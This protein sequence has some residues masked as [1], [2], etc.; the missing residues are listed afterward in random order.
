MPYRRTQQRRKVSTALEE[1]REEFETELVGALGHKVRGSR[2]LV[3]YLEAGQRGT[4]QQAELRAMR[5]S[6]VPEGPAGSDHLGGHV[7]AAG[8]GGPF[9]LGVDG[10]R[11]LGEDV[12][13]YVLKQVLAAAE[14]AVE[15]GGGHPHGAADGPQ[16]DRLRPLVHQQLPGR[17]LDLLDGGGADAVTPARCLYHV[18]LLRT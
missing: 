12:P 4:E 17:A 15:G 1:Q 5:Q 13:G 8:P 16:R 10:G 6:P 7:P 14:V 3:Q 2:A 11:D 18:A 9:D